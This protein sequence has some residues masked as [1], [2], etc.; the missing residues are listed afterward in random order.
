MKDLIEVLSSID[1][2]IERAKARA[3]VKQSLDEEELMTE[4]R[5]VIARLLF[6]LYKEGRNADTHDARRTVEWF[7]KLFKGNGHT[8]LM[9]AFAE[10][11][12]EN[13]DK[14]EPLYEPYWKKGWQ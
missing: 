3:I 12:K 4:E 14:K 9:Q 13:K 8:V 2:D 7:S 5:W 11:S 10:L 1:S 6:L